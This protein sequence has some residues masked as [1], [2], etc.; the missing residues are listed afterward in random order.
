MMQRL[1][2]VAHKAR[3]CA[4]SSTA[5]GDKFFLLTYDYVDDIL[6]KRVPHRAGH[7]AHAKAAI[8]EGKVVLGG[9]FADLKQAGI[10]FRVPDAAEVEA[11]ARSDPYVK[12]GLVT[13]HSVREWTV[14]VGEDAISGIPTL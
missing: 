11:F 1:L 2:G 5:A 7:L 3:S 13:S 8:E 12:Q 4:L 14:V 9:A 10:V 6:E